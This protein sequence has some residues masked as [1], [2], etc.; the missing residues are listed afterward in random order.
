MQLTHHQSRGRPFRVCRHERRRGESLLK[1]KF[2][3]D[4]YPYFAPKETLKKLQRQTDRCT[5]YRK[6]AGQRRE[7]R[8]R[9]QG[10]TAGLRLG[11]VQNL[12]PE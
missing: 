11:L 7:K 4:F 2:L 8:N 6:A 10:D 1:V 5:L 12:L 3:E 9:G